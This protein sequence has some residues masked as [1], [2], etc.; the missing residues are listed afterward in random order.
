MGW[1]SNNLLKIFYKDGVKVKHP[2]NNATIATPIV[3]S[4]EGCYPGT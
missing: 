1:N 4:I 2:Y 3:E